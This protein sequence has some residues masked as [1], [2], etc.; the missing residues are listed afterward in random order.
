MGFVRGLFHQKNKSAADLGNELV[1]LTSDLQRRAVSNQ[2]EYVDRL[3]PILGALAAGI[4]SG[5]FKIKDVDTFM[6]YVDRIGEGVRVPVAVDLL[7]YGGGAPSD[8]PAGTMLYQFLCLRVLMWGAPQ[9]MKLREQ[10]DWEKLLDLCEAG[11][12]ANKAIESI[13]SAEPWAP[14]MKGFALRGIGR[15]QEAAQSFREA[16]RLI[17]QAIARPDIQ[18]DAKQLAWWQGQLQMAK[19]G[20]AAVP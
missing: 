10:E 15:S 20:E 16:Q 18:Q 8:G 1:G 3:A 19:D 7:A 17:E 2:E 6:S 4:H 13:G 5:R 12:Q 9:A 14:L 11:E